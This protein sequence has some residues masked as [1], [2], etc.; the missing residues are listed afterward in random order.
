MKITSSIE[1]ETD[2]NTVKPLLSGHPR[3]ITN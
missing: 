3:E 2:L 1:D